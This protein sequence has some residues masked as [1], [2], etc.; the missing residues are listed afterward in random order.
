M[1]DTGKPYVVASIV[2]DIVFR[3]NVGVIIKL[4]VTCIDPPLCESAPKRDPTSDRPQLVDTLKEILLRVGSRSAPIGTL[5]VWVFSPAILVSCYS[6]GRGPA[7]VLIHIPSPI[8]PSTAWSIALSSI[9]QAQKCLVQSRG[10][11]N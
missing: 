3:K 7:S 10:G 2:T 11:L 1:V 5:Y 6:F 4:G 8:S 9:C